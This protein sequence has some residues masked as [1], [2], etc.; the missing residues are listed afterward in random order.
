MNEVL[1]ITAAAIDEEEESISLAKDE[2]STVE[3]VAEE[4]GIEAAERVGLVR[5]VELEDGDN[6]FASN[7][8]AAF[9]TLNRRARTL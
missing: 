5:S 9:P 6:H 3:V 2:A 1:L 7:N 4:D 8:P